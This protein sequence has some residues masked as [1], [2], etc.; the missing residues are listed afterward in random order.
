MPDNVE[1]FFYI[2]EMDEAPLKGAISDI[3]DSVD[4]FVKSTTTGLTKAVNLVSSATDATIKF[5]DAVVGTAKTA[6]SNAVLTGLR[7]FALGLDSMGFKIQY[8]TQL[9]KTGQ[10]AYAAFSSAMTGLGNTAIGMSKRVSK[11]GKWLR[12]LLWGESAAE[13]DGEGAP[14]ETFAEKFKKGGLIGI[15]KSLGPAAKSAFQLG[16]QLSTVASTIG[17]IAKVGGMAVIFGPFLP[18]IKPFMKFVGMLVDTLQPA[19]DVLTGTMKAALAPIAATL[20]NLAEDIVPILLRLMEP[21]VNLAVDFVENFADLLADMDFGELFDQFDNFA[22]VLADIADSFV[23]DFLK[24]VGGTLFR[25]VLQLFTKLALFAVKFVETIKPYLPKFFSV[26][27]QIA[28]LIIESLGDAINNLLDDL[29]ALLPQLNPLMEGLLGFFN[30]LYPQLKKILPPLFMVFSNVLGKFLVPATIEALTSVVQSLPKIVKEMGPMIDKFSEFLTNL[31]NTW[32]DVMKVKDALQELWN[33]LDMIG[34]VESEEVKKRKEMEKL[35]LQ[36]RADLEGIKKQHEETL[37]IMEKQWRL[38]GK[39]EEAIQANREKMY[40]AQ[41][42]ELELAKQA[43]AELTREEN[44]QYASET[45]KDLIKKQSTDILGETIGGFLGSMAAGPSWLRRTAVKIGGAE[46]MARGAEAVR[47]RFGLKKYQEGGYVGQQQLAM[48]GEK[49]EWIVP[50]TPEGIM[51][52][53]PSM[54][55]SLAPEM[56][57]AP[58]SAPPGGA[59]IQTVRPSAPEKLLAEIRDILRAIELSLQTDSYLPENL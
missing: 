44:I 41:K 17:A 58:A 7:S 57:T 4:V 30:E 6:A 50:D 55:R 52:Y 20:E 49:P 48:V 25:T 23:R 37:A 56:V 14:R 38:Q 53:L 46:T 15:I 24:P 47:S 36:R 5:V 40:A 29:I 35:D 27:Q 13:E 54:M 18:L 33:L 9:L 12:F 22:D 32:K 16:S 2:Y 11:G 51:R 26:L 34:I 8:Q 59:Q 10:E 43:K 3:R 1:K 28:D 39:S 19:L 45:M 31:N 42:R 21:L